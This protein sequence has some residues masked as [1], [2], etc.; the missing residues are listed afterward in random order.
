MICLTDIGINGFESF[1]N[2]NNENILTNRQIATP[3][4]YTPRHPTYEFQLKITNC[5]KIILALNTYF[6]EQNSI[7][8]KILSE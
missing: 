2:L 7:T 1:I 5:R 3:F 4:K 6:I 8:V